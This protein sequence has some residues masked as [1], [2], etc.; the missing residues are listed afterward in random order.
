MHWSVWS[1]LHWVNMLI[2]L[3][4]KYTTVL[5]H[6]EDNVRQTYHEARENQFSSHERPL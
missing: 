4:L 5:R 1:I 3:V 2:K 6:N